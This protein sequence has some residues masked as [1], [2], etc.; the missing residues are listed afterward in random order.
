[1]RNRAVSAGC[2]EQSCLLGG[3]LSTS[4]PICRFTRP[5]A[6]I[7]CHDQRKQLAKLISELWAP[8]QRAGSRLSVV[9]WMAAPSRACERK[10]VRLTHPSLVFMRS[11]AMQGV[12]AAA[13][14][15]AIRCPVLCSPAAVPRAALWRMPCQGACCASAGCAIKSMNPPLLCRR[16]GS[17]A[18]CFV[19]SVAS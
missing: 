13:P 8:R 9:G 17:G 12:P 15:A 14:S 16:S 2:A 19:R 10:P 7:P 6:Q 18:H 4:A 5:K 1:M 3:Q 11:R